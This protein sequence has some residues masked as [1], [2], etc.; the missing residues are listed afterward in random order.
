MASIDKATRKY[1]RIVI[2]DDININSC[3][4]SIQG[5]SSL[6]K[7]CDIFCLENLI[8]DTTC[9]I[10]N[11][12]SSVNVILTNKNRSFQNSSTVATGLSDVH[13]MNLTFMRVN[14][15]RL[16][17]IQIRKANLTSTLEKISFYMTLG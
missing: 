2:I 7:L 4:E 14:Y 9:E 1:D 15:E 13:K 3:D 6:T 10:S 8:R 12:S 11:S 5:F 17:P 16:K